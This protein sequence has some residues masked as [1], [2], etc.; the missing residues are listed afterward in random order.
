MPQFVHDLY[1]RQGDGEGGGTLGGKEMLEG[2]GQRVGA[3]RDHQRA[4]GVLEI[5]AGGVAAQCGEDVLG[6]GLDH[7]EIADLARL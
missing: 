2:V 6:L 4:V 3:D 7:R 5:G 1:Q